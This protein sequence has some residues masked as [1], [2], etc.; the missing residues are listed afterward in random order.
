MTSNKQYINF[1]L[2]LFFIIM[3]AFMFF[4]KQMFYKIEVKQ[5]EIVLAE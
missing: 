4:A 2:S 5:Q 3:L 1:L